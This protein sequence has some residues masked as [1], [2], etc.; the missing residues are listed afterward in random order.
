MTNATAK[1]EITPEI[2]AQ[3]FWAM[4]STEQIKFFSELAN[5]IKDDNK[6]N[7]S[8]YNLGELQWCFMSEDME[9]KENK[10]AKDMLMTMASFLYWHTLAYK[11][12]L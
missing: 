9:K 6:K 7:K 10:E 2:M 12:L 4:S 5:V 8:S 1:I 3:A 11:D